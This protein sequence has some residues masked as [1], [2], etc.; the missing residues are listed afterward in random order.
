MT[1]LTQATEAYAAYRNALVTW[2]GL[3]DEVLNQLVEDCYKAKK[4]MEVA[5]IKHTTGGVS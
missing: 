1:D 2:D 3:S 4:A 5:W